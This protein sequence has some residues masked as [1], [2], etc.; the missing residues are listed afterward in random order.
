MHPIVASFWQKLSFGN[1]NIIGA[2]EVRPDTIS[3]I[4]RAYEK[5]RN[6]LEYRA[7][8]LVRRAAIERI[9]RRQM[10]LYDKPDQVAT[11]LMTELKWAKYISAVEL[12][13]GN[14]AKLKDI[15]EKYWIHFRSGQIPSDWLTGVLSAE[16]DEIFTL[17][18]DYQIFTNFAFQI[19]KQ[20]TVLDDL[21]LFVSVD[22]VISQ[23]DDAQ[24]GYHLV[25]LC[26]GDIPTAYNLYKTADSHI[27]K[28]KA[29]SY[30]RSQQA[31][32]IL[33]RDMYFYDPKRFKGA[34]ANSE[35]F[36]TYAHTVLID[37]LRQTGNRIQTAAFRS[38]IYVF[39]TKM[40]VG[41]LLEIPVDK[42]LYGH[43][44]YLGL[45]INLLVPPL[46]MMAMAQNISL[47]NS[48]E[49]KVLIEKSWQII[50][51]FESLKTDKDI[52]RNNTYKG[53]SYYIFSGLYTIVFVA[54][55]IF[56]FYV[57]S[58]L[59]ISFV[60]QGL[61]VFF[62][63]VVS[64]FAYRIRQ[65]ANL[66]YYNPSRRGGALGEMFMLPIV[67]VGGYLSRGISYLNII[68][69]VFDFIL[70]APIKILLRFL[71]HWAQFLSIK[72][73]EVVG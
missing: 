62:L 73:D 58:K 50:S 20:K 37:Q 72:R 46:V 67:A 52:F 41:L 9:L 40:L 10:V 48:G 34:S 5:A 24:V 14:A 60:S 19:I 61:F 12:E 63:C 57:L 27:L 3:T 26:H 16:I 22:R 64:F 15:I 17:N 70:E 44:N 31:P 47:P 45:I 66:Y 28:N 35:K 11:E 43:L 30:V 29:S 53:W 36:L 2:E 4:A 13:Q 32:I 23:S 68:A 56:L 38:V 6:A 42:I 59:R 1:Q 7:D 69:F 55:F 18:V 71:D 51:N 33:L 39:L 54:I 25:K 49:Q 21:I 65:I 8:H